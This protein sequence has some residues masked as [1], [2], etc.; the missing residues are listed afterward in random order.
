MTQ[1]NVFRDG[2]VHVRAEQCENCLFSKDRLISGA[3]AKALVASTRAETGSS[4]VCHRSQVS[5]DPEAIC[6]AWWVLFANEDMILR[7]A[8]AMHMIKFVKGSESDEG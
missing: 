8:Q 1:V 4:F 6:A 5:G 7:L 2:K 3:R